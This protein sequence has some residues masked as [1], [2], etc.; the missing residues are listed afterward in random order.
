MEVS[1]PTTSELLRQLGLF[2][3]G[4]EQAAEKKALGQQ[5]FLRLLTTELRY[6][7]PT[8]PLD[9]K[10]FLAQIAQFTT[11]DG[12][13]SMQQSL[14]S[15]AEG[16]QQGQLLQAA[17]VIG[18]EALVPAPQLVVTDASPVRGEIDLPV[19]T[20]DLRVVIT[21]GVGSSVR[22][23]ELGAQAAGKVAFHWNG[24]T[25]AGDPVIPGMYQFEAEYDQGGVAATLPVRLWAKVNSISVAGQEGIRVNLDGL[26]S[27]AL[28]QVLEF[29]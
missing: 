28:P 24:A 16:M 5:D 26:P 9:S 7:D 18:R 3:P 10:D 20:G 21:D 19:A 1:Q 22:V 29:S 14:V 15:L 11:V 17:A 23:L 8:S 6:Q 4:G 2:A 13:T 27:A 12:I 25:T